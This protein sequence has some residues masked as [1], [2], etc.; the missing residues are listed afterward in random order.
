MIVQAMTVQLFPSTNDVYVEVDD[1]ESKEEDNLELYDHPVYDEYEDE[2]E[3]DIY[4][5]KCGPSVFDSYDDE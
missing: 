4:K 5:E 3:E 1:A 2:S